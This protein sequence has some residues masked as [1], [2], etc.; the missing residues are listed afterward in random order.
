MKLNEILKKHNLE[1]KDLARYLGMSP[2]SFYHSSAKERYKKAF[3]MMYND[4]NGLSQNN[5]CLTC[6]YPIKDK[7]ATE[8]YNCGRDLRIYLQ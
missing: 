2:R 8:C 1:L 5:V 4:I 6:K 3:E 7:D